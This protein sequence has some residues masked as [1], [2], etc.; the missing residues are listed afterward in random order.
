MILVCT[1]RN[2]SAG[3]KPVEGVEKT[4]EPRERERIRLRERQCE[5]EKTRKETT[6]KGKATREDNAQRNSRSP[7]RREFDY[8]AGAR[9]FQQLRYRASQQFLI[10]I[11]YYLTFLFLSVF[12]HCNA[13]TFRS[14]IHDSIINIWRVPFLKEKKTEETFWFAPPSRGILTDRTTMNLSANKK[15][16]YFFR[17]SHDIGSVWESTI[18]STDSLRDRIFDRDNKNVEGKQKDLSRWRIV[19]E[20]FF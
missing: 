17:N 12:S 8:L 16:K 15:K 6:K 7:G 9:D 18:F 13:T 10:A 19:Y 14:K 1:E 11:S 3:T 20:G 2:G 5:R 4:T